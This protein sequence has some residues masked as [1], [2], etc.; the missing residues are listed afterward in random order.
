MANKNDVIDNNIPYF[1]DN[2]SI[3]ELI[4][5]NPL[6]FQTENE[7]LVKGLPVIFITTPNL[8][9]S[10]DINLNKL[11]F[12]KYMMDVEPDLLSVLNYKGSS[13]VL[14]SG[15]PFIKILTNRFKEIN[16]SSVSM[17]T[18]TYN[19]TRY[20]FKQIFPTAII[21]SITAN[22]ISIT[23][24][25]TKNLDILKIHK[26]WVEYIEYVRRG[27]MKPSQDTI[28]SRT[29]DFTCSIYYFLLDFDM[30][31]ILYYSKYTGVA[32][33]SI[34]YDV[35]QSNVTE[36]N[37]DIIDM[38]INYTYCYKED[39]NPDILIDFNTVS[40]SAYK[41]YGSDYVKRYLYQSKENNNYVSDVV[42]TR[43][44][45]AVIPGPLGYAAGKLAS[46]SIRE[47]N[48]N[49]YNTTL[50]DLENKSLNAIK[51]D[52]L[53]NS[54]DN[55]TNNNEDII[56]GNDYSK[57]KLPVIFM[58]SYSDNENKVRYKLKY[59]VDSQE[60]DAME[61]DIDYSVLNDKEKLSEA[62][63]DPNSN[64][65]K[66]KKYLEEELEKY[67]KLVSDGNNMAGVSAETK[68]DNINKM[69]EIEKDLQSY[70]IN[71]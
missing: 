70:Q 68:L 23:Y 13:N 63:Q 49:N 21:D 62:L 27:L 54:L 4:H 31:T 7:P 5:F 56:E 55:N 14:G 53:E 42:A 38:Q 15:S 32:P 12:F 44:G 1:K 50:K 69:K 8:N 30:E 57:I 46:N 48:N 60:L 59:V 26:C 71:Q 22:D 67:K 36:K 17:R 47:S 64:E 34:P 37:R 29:I 6:H 24:S 40:S 9:L 19:E 43:I 66:R 35:L 39:M 51:K 10:K 45:M 65:S 3:D 25:E 41:L 58:N 52:T 18:G 61:S 11:G 28:V 20:G 16:L 33:T 2:R